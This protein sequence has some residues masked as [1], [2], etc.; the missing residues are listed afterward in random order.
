L[1]TF[2]KRGLE[3]SKRLIGW[4]RSVDESRGKAKQVRLTL[5]SETRVA[6]RLGGESSLRL[7]A[8]RPFSR[9]VTR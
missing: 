3:Y 2:W 8:L 4:T 9:K 6:K 1:W 7:R 5:T